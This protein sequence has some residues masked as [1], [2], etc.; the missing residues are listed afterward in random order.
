LGGQFKKGLAGSHR[1]GPLRE[2]VMVRYITFWNWTDQGI[3]KLGETVDRAENFAKTAEKS[4]LKVKE[5][6][7]T[8]GK[9]D[10]FLIHESADEMTGIAAIAQLAKLGNIRTHT[11]RAFD[12][13]EMRQI[14]AKVK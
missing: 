8:V 4:G 5:F 9:Y 6:F 11:L 10:G 1:S 3:S 12:S 14:L 13:S 2:F 7:W